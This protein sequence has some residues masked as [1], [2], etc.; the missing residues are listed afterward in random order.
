MSIKFNC[1]HCRKSLKVSTELAGKRARC[2]GC[3][4]VLT[5]PTLDPPPA[6]LEELAA[7]ALVDQPKPEP[8][9]V[10][11]A[12]API[13]FHCFYCD[14]DV[15]VEAE[16][17][18]KQTPCPHCRRIVKVP[19]P[20]KTEPRDW[21]KAPP[22]GPAAGLRRDEPPPPEGAWGTATSA[23]TV[24]RQAL[25]D[26][27]AIPMAEEGLTT[28][29]WVVRGLLATAAVL[30]VGAGVWGLLHLRGQNLQKKALA[31]ALEAISEKADSPLGNAG[32]AEINRAAGEY[33][34]REGKPALA[35]T[36][37]VQAQTRLGREPASTKSA[38]ERD[39]FAIDLALTQIDLFGNQQ[40]VDK[41][42]R[43]AW[44]DSARQIGHTLQ[45]IAFPEARLEALRQVSRKL[46]QKGQVDVAK[47]I[48]FE[49]SSE[50]QDR[51]EMLAVVGLELFRD[52]RHDAAQG[53]AE[54]ALESYGPDKPPSPAPSLAA[55]LIALK[56]E[57]E[58]GEAFRISAPQPDV[59]N[60][61]P[62][63]RLAF[64]QGWAY[65]EN[66]EPAQVLAAAPGP[67]VE[68]LNALVAVAAVAV[69][70]NPA[71]AKKCLETALALPLAGVDPW[72]LYR[73]I[74]L[75]AELGLMEQL[76]PVVDSEA[77]AEPGLRRLAQ[78]AVL[79][80]TLKDRADPEVLAAQVQQENPHPPTLQWLAR[81]NAR[82]GSASS[83]LHAIAGWEPATLRPFGYIGAALGMQDSGK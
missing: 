17:A 1:P 32:A 56:Q 58:A 12:A 47:T 49:M 51:P 20:V 15:E 60:P 29:Q 53:L 63:T 61:A 33:Y 76:K 10:R 9:P 66:W 55:L 8:E 83:V 28:A 64:A 50:Q 19:E 39:A 75:G 43:A 74:Q 79:R 38:S 54:Q 27:E 71:A 45:A 31:L 82:Y 6:E 70:K 23:S 18:G 80:A 62:V 42:I 37:F 46:I 13:K 68:R 44:R 40:E 11:Q 26:A 57:K 67:P 21:R 77:F 35:H 25:I 14:E 16:L 59:S 7:A 52:G 41:G 24:S 34:L 3:K 78:L 2:N 69:E 22:R 48:A 36:Q 73:L 72:S 81:Q 65:Q 4:Q 5:I 30:L